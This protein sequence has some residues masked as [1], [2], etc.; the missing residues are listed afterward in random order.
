MY[1]WNHVGEELVFDP[2]LDDVDSDA[3]V[4]RNDKGYDFLLFQIRNI[5]RFLT[6]KD[7]YKGYKPVQVPLLCSSRPHR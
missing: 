7:F 2:I 3:L 1:L 4:F 5:I 6:T